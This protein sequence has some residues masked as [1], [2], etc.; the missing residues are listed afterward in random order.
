MTTVG[1]VL[2]VFGGVAGFAFGAWC[3]V[4]AAN[5]LFPAVAR[6][7]SDLV[8]H[9]A[10]S[11]F[12][13]GVLVGTP[14]LFVSVAL[15]GNPMPL[16]K[17]VGLLGVVAVLVVATVGFAGLARL[18]G[19]RV[20]GSG[21]STSDYVGMTRGTALLVGAC[22]IPLIG[23]FVVAPVCLLFNFGAGLGA[24]LGRSAAQVPSGEATN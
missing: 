5:L 18:T 7:A 22:V 3:L 11:Q 9:R 13:R 20:S 24:L 19:R 14:A 1:D 17:V 16:M 15:V 6:R 12:M 8:E 10:S 21:G 23:W 2:M 4:L